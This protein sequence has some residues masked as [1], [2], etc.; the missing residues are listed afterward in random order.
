MPTE[1]IKQLSKILKSIMTSFSKV[2]P[3]LDL[4]NAVGEDLFGLCVEAKVKGYQY[5]IDYL[6]RLLMNFEPMPH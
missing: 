6:C 3:F 5:G 4:I 2:M 1:D